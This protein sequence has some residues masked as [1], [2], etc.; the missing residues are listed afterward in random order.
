ML[1]MPLINFE[2]SLILTWSATCVIFTAA[3]NQAATFAVTDTKLYIPVVTLSIDDNVKLLQQNQDSNAH[4]TG[5]N[6]NQ[7]QQHSILQINILILMEPSFWGVNR[8][9]VL[10]FN[11]SDS[12]IGHSSYFLPTAIVE[13]CSDGWKKVF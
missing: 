8:L 7:K 10:T 12:R 3:A 6:M 2:I 4:L 5:I 1:E 9:F 11:A 13:D